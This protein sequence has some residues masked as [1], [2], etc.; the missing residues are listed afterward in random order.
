MSRVADGP[1]M[2]LESYW[3]V[4][5]KTSAT[6]EGATGTEAAVEAIEAGDVRS[7]VEAGIDRSRATR[8]LRHAHSA[9]GMEL[10]ATRDARTVYKDILDAEIGRASCRERVFPVV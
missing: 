9:G 4:G 8:I 2:E 1:D 5:P 10:L 6:L 7:L 3:G